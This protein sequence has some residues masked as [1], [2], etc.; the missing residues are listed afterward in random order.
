MILVLFYLVFIVGEI[1]QPSGGHMQ[2]KG[3]L[4]GMAPDLSY[5]NSRSERWIF[6]EWNE[7]NISRQYVLHEIVLVFVRLIPASKF[8]FTSF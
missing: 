1:L 4:A 6:R 7:N 3:I 2:G 5:D 8:V